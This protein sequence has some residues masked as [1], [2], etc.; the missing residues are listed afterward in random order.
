MT[1]AAAVASKKDQIQ[2]LAQANPDK[3]VTKSP[4]S[5]KV[6]TVTRKAPTTASK[7]A[8]EVVDLTQASNISNVTTERGNAAKKKPRIAVVEAPKRGVAS[9]KVPSK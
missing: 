3:T 7:P 9:S 2:E 8:I 1:A 4:T 5:S 6:V